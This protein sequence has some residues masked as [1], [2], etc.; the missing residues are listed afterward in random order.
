MDGVSLYDVPLWLVDSLLQRECF[1][2]GN[3]RSGLTPR[4]LLDEDHIVTS[5]LLLYTVPC[6]FLVDIAFCLSRYVCFSPFEVNLK[7]CDYNVVLG[8]ILVFNIW[9]IVIVRQSKIWRL[10][11]TEDML[12]KFRHS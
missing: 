10:K 12:N 6:F 9:F 2:V 8:S 5:L 3:S 11:F 4:R 1:K 7:L